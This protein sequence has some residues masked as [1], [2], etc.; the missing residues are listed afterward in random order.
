MRLGLLLILLLALGNLS[1]S[2]YRINSQEVTDNVYA[3]K[4]SAA[5]VVYL[6]K[7]NRAYE[8]IGF[9]TVNTERRQ[10]QEDVIAKMKKEAAVLGGDAI[11][12]LQV[13]ATDTWK[14]MP[15]QELLKNGYIRA[16]FTATV[17]AFK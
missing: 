17:V 11:T 12:N 4:N 6:E 9:V 1:C 10:N 7:I 8:V 16:N 14:K 2:I 13:E 5:D 3:P 15:A